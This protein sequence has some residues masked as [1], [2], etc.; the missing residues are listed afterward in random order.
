ELEID[1]EPLADLGLVVEQAVAGVDQDA[2]DEDRVGHVR[3][4]MAAAIF[5]ACTVS[6]TSW[7]RMMLAPCCTAK[8]CAAME[9]P[10]RCGGSEGVTA[11]MKLLRDA[12]TSSGQPKLLSSARR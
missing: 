10:S 1:H 5:S 9:P 7:V 4:P 2:A 6:A 12:P 11:A 3:L 8:R